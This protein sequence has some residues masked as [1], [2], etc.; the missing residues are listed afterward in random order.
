MEIFVEFFPCH[1]A[2]RADRLVNRAGFGDFKR[3]GLDRA[4]EF[5]G[6]VQGFAGGGFENQGGFGGVQTER[7]AQVIAKRVFAA[8]FGKARGDVGQVA[9]RAVRSSVTVASPVSSH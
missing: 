2:R 4:C 8:W 6:V 3:E 7:F 1:T 5:G 9:V